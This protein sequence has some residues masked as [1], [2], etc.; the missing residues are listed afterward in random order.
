MKCAGLLDSRFMAP[1]QHQTIP[2]S[3][4]PDRSF[5]ERIKERGRFP[6][7]HEGASI[8]LARSILRVHAVRNHPLSDEQRAKAESCNDHSLLL[9]WL[10]T[11]VQQN[12]YQSFAER[13]IESG[14]REGLAR[15][16]IAGL[17]EGILQILDARDIAMPD[18]VRAYIEACDNHEVLDTWLERSL[19]EQTIDGLFDPDVVD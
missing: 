8:G 1:A 19:T 6:A 4:K 5:S 10:H 14:R 11:A 7:I 13:L 3:Q 18:H 16:E 2:D 9:L 12:T 15:G 17:V